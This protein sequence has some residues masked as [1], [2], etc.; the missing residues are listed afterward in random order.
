MFLQQICDRH[1]GYVPE[2]GAVEIT[3]DVDDVDGH[4][5]G[6][7]LNVGDQATGLVGTRSR[8]WTAASCQALTCLVNEGDFYQSKLSIAEK[9]FEKHNKDLAKQGLSRAV[10]PSNEQLIGDAVSGLSIL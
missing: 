9:M 3:E 2:I 4:P 1:L 5:G 7:R 8:L 6:N 10:F